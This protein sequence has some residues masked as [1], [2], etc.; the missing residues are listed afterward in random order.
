MFNILH[1]ILRELLRRE[2]SHTEEVSSVSIK[3]GP[4]AEPKVHFKSMTIA[5]KTPRSDTVGDKDFI[6]VVFQR[7]PYWVLFRCPCGCRIVISLSLQKMHRPHWTVR[8][9]SEGRPT[10]Y[11]SV[12]Q[13]NGCCSHF[14]IR[15]G[16]VYWCVKGDI[17]L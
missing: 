10:V 14:L 12:W 11:P 6:M 8:K 1:K 2:S 16:R 5:N 3:S 4:L 15:D 9:N 17:E 13:N 7:K